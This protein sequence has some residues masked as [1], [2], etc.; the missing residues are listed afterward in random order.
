MDEIVK[1]KT[2]VKKHK[3]Q[4]TLNH[5]IAMFQKLSLLHMMVLGAP[6]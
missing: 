1:T 5:T 6:L 3:K 2:K 4:K